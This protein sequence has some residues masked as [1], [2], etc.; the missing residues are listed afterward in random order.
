MISVDEATQIIDQTIKDFGI[1]H[2]ALDDAVGRILREDLYADRDF[3]PY[4]RVTMDGIAI[5]SAS[6]AVDKPFLIA[7]VAAAGAPK[8]ELQDPNHCLE[9]MT[10]AILPANT[11]AVIRYEDVLIENGKATIQVDKVTH[12]QNVHRKGFDRSE[13]SLVVKEG[14]QISPAE[15]GVAATIGKAQI[16]VSKLP[17]TIIISTGDELVEVDKTPLPYQIR[18]SNVHRLLATMKAY[19]IDADTE[20][21]VDDLDAVTNRL[22]EILQEYEVI[23]L[24]GGVSKGKF[25]YLPQ[26]LESLGVEKLFHKIKQ[27][28]GKPFWFGKSKEGRLIFALPG[29]PVSS[30]MCTQIYVVDWLRQSIG[31]PKLRRAYGV[32]Q[33][34]VHFKPDLTY[35]AQVK[36]S[37]SEEGKIVALPVEGH[38]SGD[39]AN[40]VD[41]DAFIRIPRGQDM[42]EAGTVYPLYFYR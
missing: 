22:R 29:N 9:V 7:G 6:F 8:M 15:I 35:F 27:R 26:A 28:P 34:A 30:F 12:G 33:K 24:S 3:P 41:A 4:D 39:L 5:Q 32:L 18:R 23:I 42:F 11:D 37:Y 2:I 21:L 20:H 38:G 25:D 16:A 19:N 1:E 40:L 14:R 31:L 17:K 10:G 13:G 36:I